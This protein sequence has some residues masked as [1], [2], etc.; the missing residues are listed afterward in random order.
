MRLE[1]ALLYVILEKEPPGGVGAFCEAAIA[2][3]VDVIQLARGLAD[4]ASVVREVCRRTDALFIVSDDAAVAAASG[5]DGTHI[6][7]ATEPV[8]QYRAVMGEK[9]LVGVSTRSRNDALLALEMGV[10]Y[11]LHWEGTGCAAAFASLPGAAGN[12]LFAAG[13]TGLDDARLLV[14]SGV[15]RLCIDAG[16][17]DGAD[18]TA[19][20]AAY[21][22]ILGRS[23]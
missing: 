14:E 6:S 12:A 3:G 16:A 17:L 19:S 13:L 10:D 1:D 9:G 20:A 21:S 23:I 8:G 2:G 4:E 22:R 11:L 18:V 7:D 5:A 15:Y